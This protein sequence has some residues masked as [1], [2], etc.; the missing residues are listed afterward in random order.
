MAIIVTNASIKNDI[1]TSVS[2]IHIC[3]HS[4]IK[5]VHHAAK[6]KFPKSSSSLTPSMQLKR[7][8][9]I[10]PIRIKSI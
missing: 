3:D 1:T 7:Y 4:L 5:T 8:S 6:I 10:K 2:H 9:M